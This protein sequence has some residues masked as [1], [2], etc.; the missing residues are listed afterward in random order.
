MTGS[1]KQIKWANEILAPAIELI[2]EFPD[3]IR[4]KHLR[5]FNQ[6]ESAAKVIGSR[7]KIWNWCERVEEWLDTGIFKTSILFVPGYDEPSQ[8]RSVIH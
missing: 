3:S 2:D 1:E 6:I 8:I 5:S 7:G 4:E